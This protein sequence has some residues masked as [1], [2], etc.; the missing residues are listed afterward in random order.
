MTYAP[1]RARITPLGAKLG[2]ASLSLLCFASTAAAE[3]RL[4]AG[5]VLE[6]SVAGCRICGS[7]SWSNS[8]VLSRTHCSA[9]LPVAGLPPSE[10]RAKI[11]SILPTKVFRQ[12]TPE[13]RESVV[14]LQPDQVTASVVEYRPIYVNGERVQ[15]WRADLSSSYDRTSGRGAIRRVRDDAIPDH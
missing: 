5:D 12:R 7:A 1:S 13:G 2:V 10:V 3:Y 14:I 11:Q 6:I 8:M 9:P 4:D 15:A